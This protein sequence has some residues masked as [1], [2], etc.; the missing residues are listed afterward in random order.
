MSGARV[1]HVGEEGQV[2]LARGTPRFPLF[3]LSPRV[4][5][6]LNEIQNTKNV[7]RDP[8]KHPMT[9]AA[10]LYGQPFKHQTRGGSVESHTPHALRNTFGVCIRSFLRNLQRR[11]GS[12]LQ[13]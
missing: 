11:S 4:C 10:T 12:A 2:P 13:S 9:H 8:R 5:P 7:D 6:N 3:W 1:G